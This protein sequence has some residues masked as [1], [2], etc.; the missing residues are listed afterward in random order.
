[1]SLNLSS[2]GI[3]RKLRIAL[4]ADFPWSFFSDGATGRG[5]GQAAT[6]LTQLSEEFGKQD[7][8]E[9]HW[10][11]LARR[12]K[13]GGTHEWNHQYFHCIPSGRVSVDLLLGYQPAKRRLMKALGSIKP[14]LVHCWGSEQEYAVVCEAVKVPTVF[15][16]QG[17]LSYLERLGLLPSIWQWKKIA[18]WE[19]RFLRSAKVI[20]A[21]SRWA[22]DRILEV[23]P[24]ADVRQV[25]YGVNPSFYKV[26]W[27]PDTGE[28]YAIFVGA[29]SRGK[30]VDVLLD[31][32]RQLEDRT[33]RLKMVGDGELRSAVT[34]SGI[35]GIEWL[36]TLKWDQ[37]QKELAGAL[38]L[39]LPTRADS[40][41]N[42]VKEA[43]VI[44]LPVVTTRHG[45]QSGYILDGINGFIVEP[46]ESEGLAAAL[47]RLMNDIPLALQMGEARHEEDRDYFQPR[48]TAEKFL[49]IYRK[50]LEIP[51]PLGEMP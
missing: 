23:H 33:W 9:I 43:R 14:D 44:G 26:P 35:A 31:A 18:Q 4:L 28:P 39:V 12:D 8:F 50:L 51:E 20:T 41:P 45:G 5:G 24:Q 10:V 34:G 38:C 36:P 19:P 46:L 13:N 22:A 25:E 37:L 21:E 16:V 49:S 29:I 6:W 17:V 2:N 42:V 3:C 11:S 32:L 7:D 48:H 1:M 15:S 30:G 40:S 47:S 27:A